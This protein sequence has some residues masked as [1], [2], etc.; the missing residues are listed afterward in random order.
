[1]NCFDE[2]DLFDKYNYELFSIKNC[3]SRYEKFVYFGRHTRTHVACAESRFFLCKV[4]A[5]PVRDREPSRI[6]VKKITSILHKS[7]KVRRMLRTY[8]K[9]N[10][11]RSSR[12][13]I[14][15]NK[16]RAHDIRSGQKRKTKYHFSAIK[17]IKYNRVRSFKRMHRKFHKNRIKLKTNYLDRLMKSTSPNQCNACKSRSVPSVYKDLNH[18]INHC[19]FNLSKD[20]ETNPGPPIDPTKT[21]HAPYSQDNVL[22]FGSNAGTQ[23][24]AMALTSLI[25]NFRNGITSSMDLFNI[26]NI[27]NELYSG[28]STLSRQSYLLL[29]EIPEMVTLSSTNYQLQYSPSYTGAICSSYTIE[30][31]QLLYAT[32]ECYAGF[33]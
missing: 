33:A 13:H 6:P 18:R 16:G 20:V 9:K 2:C 19:V 26:M 14:F 4:R 10:V 25:Y 32:G 7:R 30:D 11:P 21:I 23:C 8:I 15:T 3:R 27:G 12:M 1:M 29:T 22:V 24:V 31:F 17:R 5:V 28:L